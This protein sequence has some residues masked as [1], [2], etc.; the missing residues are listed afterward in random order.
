[1]ANN[2]NSGM[3]IWTSLKVNVVF[4]DLWKT[5]IFSL[6][7]LLQECTLCDNVMFQLFRLFGEIGKCP[8]IML[9]PSSVDIVTVA[10]CHL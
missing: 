10:C 1:M 2:I 4:L 8:T 3:K 9:C 7:F 6:G 5:S